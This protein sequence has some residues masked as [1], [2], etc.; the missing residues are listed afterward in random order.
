PENL[1]ALSV[2]ARTLTQLKSP[3]APKYSAQLQALQERRQLTDRVQQL[4]NFALQAANDN[5]WPSALDQLQQ[6]IDLCQ[7]CPQLG[8]LRKNLGIIYARKGDV[9]NAKQQLQLAVKLLPA[10][11]DTTTIAELLQRLSGSE[12]LPA[13]N[14]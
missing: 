4:N 7:Q 9:E 8:T 14:H 1:S 3:D 13:Q 11:G 10:G 12:T 6:A 2:L 5:N